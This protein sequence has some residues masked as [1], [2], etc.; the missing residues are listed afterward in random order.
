[1]SPLSYSVNV[2]GLH[3]VSYLHRLL[4]LKYPG[5]QTHVT[6]TRAQEILNS[7]GFLALD[8][9][10]EMREWAAGSHDDLYRIIQLPYSQVILVSNYKCRLAVGMH[11]YMQIHQTLTCTTN[12]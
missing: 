1:M 2:G 12:G 5:L 10:T 7:H 6:L 11:G 4:Q 8:Y 3:T 9:P